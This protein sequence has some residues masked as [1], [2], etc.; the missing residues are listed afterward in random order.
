MKINFYHRPLSLGGVEF[1]I[2][3]AYSDNTLVATSLHRNPTKARDQLR[4][5][6]ASDLVV[7]T[8]GLV[9]FEKEVDRYL[10][11]EAVI[12]QTPF[13]LPT[14]TEFQRRL[15]I[16]LSKI[17]PGRAVTYG[18]IAR[19]SGSPGGARAAGQACGKNPLPLRIPCHRV[20]AAGGKLG[21]F[22]GDLEV[23]KAL[24]E[25]EGAR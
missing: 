22:T 16:A 3:S 8:R 23:K 15:W 6:L 13:S 20:V 25:L 1:G 14:T 5:V 24:L 7:S 9:S 17:E 4:A 2:G 12:W 21:G 10:E 18:E 19:R 11:G